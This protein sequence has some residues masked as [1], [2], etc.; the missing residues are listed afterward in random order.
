M[1][2]HLDRF[3][4]KLY[5]IPLLFMLLVVLNVNAKDNDD[6]LL[7]QRVNEES[8][9]LISKYNLFKNNLYLDSAVILINTN[10]RLCQQNYKRLSLRLLYIYSVQSRYS[11]AL[12]F[13]GE[14]NPDSFQEPYTK[15]FLANR[16]FAMNAV[17]KND[18]LNQTYYINQ[19]ILCLDQYL[20][21]KED[22]VD[23]LSS[24]TDI[25]HILDNPLSTVI[26]QYFYYQSLLHPENDVVGDIIYKEK[27]FNN[28]SSEFHDFIFLW[29][30]EDFAIFKGI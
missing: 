15:Q 26:I 11:D 25:S 2:C 24:V 14:L 1:F 30:A 21:D 20:R 27:R 9:E 28:M 18:Q 23:S 13:I 8:L 19:I 7:C 3:D 16:F 6:S 22:E 4:M 29:L 5:A 17:M 12:N 10:L